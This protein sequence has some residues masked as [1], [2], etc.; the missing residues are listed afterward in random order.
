MDAVVRE[1]RTLEPGD[2]PLRILLVGRLGTLVQMSQVHSAICQIYHSFG[3]LGTAR[4]A[5]VSR[6]SL[7]VGGERICLCAVS[8]AL[9]SAGK[10]GVAAWQL[11][12]PVVVRACALAV[13]CG[14]SKRQR[15]RR[16]SQTSESRCLSCSAATEVPSAASS[17]SPG[18]AFSPIGKEDPWLLVV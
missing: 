14:S 6:F 15:Q 13:R 12:P 5:F 1:E 18:E 8:H 11:G 10:R 9:F 4:L 3:S 2:V 17:A 7:S 16:E